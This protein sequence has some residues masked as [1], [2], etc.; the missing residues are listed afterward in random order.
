MIFDRIYIDIFYD[1]SFK[2]VFDDAELK[3]YD[4][5]L[6][7]AI[8]NPDHSA[9]VILVPFFSRVGPILMTFRPLLSQCTSIVRSFGLLDY[10]AVL[11]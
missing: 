2:R 7:Q 5:L 10:S 4:Y 1:I 3:R 9:R 6:K 11:L 8:S